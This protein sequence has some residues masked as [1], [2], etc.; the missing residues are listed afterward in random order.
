MNLCLA[1]A[2]PPRPLRV[3]GGVSAIA[4]GQLLFPQRLAVDPQSALI[5]ATL[6]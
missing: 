6:V 5:K 3:V 2:E 4:S 1:F